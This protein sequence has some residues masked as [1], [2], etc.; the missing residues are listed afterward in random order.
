[1]CS[2]CVHFCNILMFKTAINAIKNSFGMP[3]KSKYWARNHTGLRV[4]EPT[5]SA[6]SKKDM[7]WKKSSS[8]YKIVVL[9]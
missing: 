8:G 1:M 9:L 5:P 2:T 3:Q 6:T 4:Y 7:T